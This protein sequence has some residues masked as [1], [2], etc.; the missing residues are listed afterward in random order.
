MITD[1]ND[2]DLTKRYTY[3]D[4]LTWQFDEMVELIRGQV[5]RMSPAPLSAHQLISMEISGQIYDYLKGEKCKVVTA[6]FDV[7]LPLPAD[8]QTDTK[9]DTVVQPDICVIC[10]LSKID[11]RGCL[12]APD[13]IIEILSKSTSKKDMTDKFDVYQN[14]GVKEYWGVH[15]ETEM[16]SAFVLN[17]N[18]IYEQVRTTP[19]VNTE[20]VPV[21]IF[22]GFE[23]VLEDIFPENL[24]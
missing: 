10:D 3:S 18:G 7:R 24:D 19:F 11:R 6:P 9:I 23:I 12:G 5:F 8:K 16:V 1:I 22:P 13:W 2:L 15:P 14:A 21:H 17:E 20:S 4:Y